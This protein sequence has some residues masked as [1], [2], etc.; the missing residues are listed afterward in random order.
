[1]ISSESARVHQ[2][3]YSPDHK[4]ICQVIESR[5][6]WGETSCRAWL[7]GRDSVVRVPAS[8]LKAL[9]SGAG[10]AD[11]IA[12]VAAA[13]RVADVL[14]HGVLH[15]ECSR[16]FRFKEPNKPDRRLRLH[17]HQA[18]AVKAAQSGDNYVLTT[19]AGSPTYLVVPSSDDTTPSGPMQ[20]RF[21]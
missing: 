5:T 16:I 10:S 15:G 18:D 6:L 13:A 4:H 11:N 14:T 20:D 3:L 17:K 9:D 8:K 2:W 12:Y 21:L 19:G 1:M 7:P